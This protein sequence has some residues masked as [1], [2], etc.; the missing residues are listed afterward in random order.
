[1]SHLN[2]TNKSVFLWLLI[3]LVQG[4]ASSRVGE[5]VPGDVDRSKVPVRTIEMTAQK[6]HFTPDSVHVE[7]GT[8][9]RIAITGLD[10]THGFSL[11]DFGIDE[12]IA[13]GETKMIEFFA[14]GKGEHAFHCSHFCG[15]GHFGMRGKVIVE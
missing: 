14:R 7:S 12:T 3:L 11:S 15:L 1:M 5:A 2:L 6:F 13:E 10:G 9:L 4:C 8:L